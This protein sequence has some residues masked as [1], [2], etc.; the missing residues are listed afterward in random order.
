MSKHFIQEQKSCNQE[1]IFGW[2]FPKHSYL[3]EFLQKLVGTN[4]NCFQMLAGPT[5]EGTTIFI[6][7]QNL[8][9]N[10]FWKF[11]VIVR[12]FIYSSRVEFPK[13]PRNP[14]RRSKIL[15]YLH[16]LSTTVLTLYRMW[17]RRRRHSA[18]CARRHTPQ[19]GEILF[20]GAF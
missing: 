16:P 10:I 3:N 14:F 4:P 15:N 7:R 17:W 20:V 1:E 6:S 12:W 8:V 13:L 2:Y 11:S 5:S 9:M 19:W 18:K